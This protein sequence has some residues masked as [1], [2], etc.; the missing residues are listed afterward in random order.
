M[1]VLAALVIYGTG[2]TILKLALMALRE[3][4]RN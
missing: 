3:K 2:T 4:L 1:D